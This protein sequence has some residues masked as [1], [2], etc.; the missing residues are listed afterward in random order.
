MLTLTV[1][2]WY[3]FKYAFR[4]K[5]QKLERTNLNYGALA[6]ITRDG[7]FW[8]GLPPGITTA[9]YLTNFVRL[10][11]SS[12]SP[13]SRLIFPPPSFRRVMSSFGILLCRLF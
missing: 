2:T 10:S 13:S 12:A 11:S 7:G 1:G 8:V 9:V 4:R 5:A 3:A 6:R